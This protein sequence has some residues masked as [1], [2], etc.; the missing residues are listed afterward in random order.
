MFTALL[1]DMIR[2][3]SGHIVAIGSIQGKLAIPFRSACTFVLLYI[4]MCRFQLSTP[5]RTVV[6]PRISADFLGGNRTPSSVDKKNQQTR[7]MAQLLLG[8]PTVLPIA[9]ELCKSSGTFI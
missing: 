2:R 4:I 9:D 8:W 1:P 6:L 7:Q 5:H 3:N